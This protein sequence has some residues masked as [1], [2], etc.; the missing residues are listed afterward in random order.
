MSDQPKN[1]WGQRVEAC[2]TAPEPMRVDPVPLATA[3]TAEGGKWSSDYSRFNVD[4][5]DDV[6]EEQ[7]MP[8]GMMPPGMPPG[9]VPLGMQGMQGMPPGMLPPEMMP[10][11]MNQQAPQGPVPVSKQTLADGTE[12]MEYKKGD[13]DV[14]TLP[15]G[16]MV[17]SLEEVPGTAEFKAR[18]AKH[19]K[20]A[21]EKMV[22]PEVEKQLG[23]I[24][25]ILENKRDD[26]RFRAFVTKYFWAYKQDP[27]TLHDLRDMYADKELKWWAHANPSTKLLPVVLPE[28][29]DWFYEI[30][31]NDFEMIVDYFAQNNYRSF[32]SKCEEDIKKWAPR[33]PASAGGMPLHELEGVDFGPKNLKFFRAWALSR[34]IEVWFSQWKA[35]MEGEQAGCGFV[36]GVER[37]SVNAY[38]KL[39]DYKGWCDPP[40]GST[41][42]KFKTVVLKRALTTTAKAS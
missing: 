14:S 16:R 4:V 37:F 17:Q 1:K 20:E 38:N 34:M 2:T 18:A 32:L 33:R 41:V 11:A 15:K 28:M 6:E 31:N 10:F 23:R 8:P 35:G 24:H 12:I 29:D 40:P 7:E 5:E 26:Q 3:K 19:F 22:R 21:E 9:G 42:E 36:G 30:G 25:R 39:H 27:K 13:I